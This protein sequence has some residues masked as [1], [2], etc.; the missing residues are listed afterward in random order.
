MINIPSSID[1]PSPVSKVLSRLNAA[2]CRAYAV[3]GCTRDALMGKTPHDWD[4]TTDAPPDIVKEIF[5]DERV[6]DTGIRHGTVTIFLGGMPIETTT[7][8]VDGKYRDSRH[9]D[10]VSFTRSLTDD[11]SR[12]DFTMNAIAY[13]PKEGFLD[14]FGGMADIE[15]GIIRAVGNPEKRFSED[16][17]RIMRAVR[18]S[19]TLGF[20]ID[21]E[22]EEAIDSCRGL[23]LNI[24]VERVSVELLKTL[25]G[26][27]AEQA[28]RDHG[29][30]FGVIIPELLPLIADKALWTKT[31]AGVAAVEPD[32][33][34]KLAM[35]FL[36]SGEVVTKNA[37]VAARLSAVTAKNALR[38]MKM[39]KK[40]IL[41]V[42]TLIDSCA[43]PVPDSKAGV[44]RMLRDIGVDKFNGFLKIKTAAGGDVS[45]A[46]QLLKE[47]AK[48]RE[49][50]LLKH[51]AVNGNDIPEDDPDRTPGE[52]LAYLLE[53][54]IADPGLNNRETLL[55]RIS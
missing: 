31:A 41:T 32:D 15:A 48:N 18:F 54:V 46:E 3:G 34:L 13:N 2:G 11:L 26:D 21:P 45:Q 25:S 1:I 49:P 24:S 37:A 50:Y 17:L 44:K 5:A 14:P 55:Q 53:L 42:S 52:I 47:I 30:M 7:F 35:L 28:L 20:S 9:P 4:V 43:K 12:R 36:Y 8:R 16:A 38:R 10:R 19:S 39:P 51:L 6:I 27:G 33:C 23:L 40:T 22:A 29:G